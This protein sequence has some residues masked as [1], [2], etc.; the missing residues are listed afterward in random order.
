MI[1]L[2]M[3]SGSLMAFAIAVPF[4]LFVYQAITAAEEHYLRTKYGQEFEDYCRRVNRFIPSFRGMNTTMASLTYDWK[5]A[6]RKEYGTVF[7]MVLFL[8][9]MPLWRVS[10]LPGPTT[11]NHLLP[12]LIVLSAVSAVLY[13]TAWV[14]KKSGVLK[15]S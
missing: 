12:A 4:F 5:R 10:F 1:G 6:I 3:Y 11:P 7:V 13:L 15:S 8:I 9:W 14:L 2:A